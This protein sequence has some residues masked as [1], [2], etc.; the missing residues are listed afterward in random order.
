MREEHRRHL[1]VAALVL[2]LGAVG[3][4]VAL[5]ASASASGCAAPTWETCVV[6]D[7]RR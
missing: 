1:G 6:E 4:V 3:A 5:W 2:W 7:V